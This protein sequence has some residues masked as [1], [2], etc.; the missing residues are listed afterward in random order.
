MI[1]IQPKS[2]MNKTEARYAQELEL[3]KRAGDIVDY[4]FESFN[5]RL[6]DNTY[7]RPD[8]LIVHKDCFE[9]IEVKGFLRDDANVKC[10][11]GKELY[12]CFKWKMVFWKNK[13]WMERL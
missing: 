10:K 7:Y 11:M 13:Q 2:R 3:R 12:P 9:F 8:F 1:P 4:Y 5:L 6:A